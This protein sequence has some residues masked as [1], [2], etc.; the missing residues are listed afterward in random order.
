MRQN[1][2][3]KDAALAAECTAKAAVLAAQRAD[4]ACCLKHL[5]KDILAGRRYFKQYRQYKTY[6]DPRLNPALAKRR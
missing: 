4:L 1:A 5:Y 3:L 2:C 6:N